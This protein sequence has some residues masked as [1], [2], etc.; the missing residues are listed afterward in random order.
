[1][2]RNSEGMVISRG[3]T[4]FGLELPRPD[5]SWTWNIA[6][7]G[8]ASRAFSKDLTVGAWHIR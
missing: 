2:K 4:V 5:A 3:S 1:V 6:P 7:I 8:E